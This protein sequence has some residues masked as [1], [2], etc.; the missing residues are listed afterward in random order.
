MRC[1]II[2]QFPVSASAV[3]CGRC[4]TLIATIVWCM[5][6]FICQTA[7]PL[8]AQTMGSYKSKEYNIRFDIPTT[9]SVSTGTQQDGTPYLE[10]TSADN[11]INMAVY[12]YD[13]KRITTRELMD[14]TL[15]NY[16][17]QRTEL[18]SIEREQINGLE[19]Y[20][21]TGMR[22]FKS[23]KATAILL[24]A[25]FGENTIVVFITSDATTFES[26]R[27]LMNRILD[28]FQQLRK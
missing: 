21:T 16:D 3:P 11:T 20:T 7:I 2:Q 27:P 22:M 28:S 12:V 23:K 9:W 6:C 26:N 19:A 14:E 25:T 5:V 4:A 24:T 1:S 8:S 13:R 15:K 18:Q 17:V 10:A